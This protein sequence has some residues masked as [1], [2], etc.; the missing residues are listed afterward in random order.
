LIGGGPIVS[1]LKN[2]LKKGFSVFVEKK[3]AK[4]IRDDL[5]EVADLGFNLVEAVENPDIFLSEIDFNLID[6]L[7]KIYDNY[8]L[9]Y[10]VAVQDHGYIQG[11]S[12][13][14]TRMNF[15]EDFLKDG[16]KNAFFPSNHEIPNTFSRFN[17]IYNE[18]VKKGIE[19]F[20][21]TDTAIIAALGA[22]YNNEKWPAVTV[23]IGNGHTFACLVDKDYKVLGFFEHHTKMLTPEKFKYFIDKLIEGSIT[24]K[25]VYDD[26]GHGAK[27]F[28]PYSYKNLPI[29]VTGP[30]RRSLVNEGGNIVF[31]SPLGDM[32]ITGPVGIFMQQNLL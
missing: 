31:A 8:D 16:L 6:T 27:I 7:L 13:R 22:V 5:S 24:N 28:K 3:A 14:V 25:E 1:A 10:N 19:N 17:S 15:L 30:Q 18:L 9:E 23:D 20:S 12:D 21:I 11:Q 4:T 32:M 2:H 26:K 29:L